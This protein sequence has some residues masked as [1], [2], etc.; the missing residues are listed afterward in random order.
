MKQTKH[1]LQKKPEKLTD[2]DL[3]YLM[4]YKQAHLQ[5]RAKG[6]VFRQR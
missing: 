6:G 2:R 4:D 3:N 5:E 1:K